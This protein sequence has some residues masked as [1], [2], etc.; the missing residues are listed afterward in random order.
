MVKHS[1]CVSNYYELYHFDAELAFME[2]VLRTPVKI[3]GKVIAANT[4]RNWFE[5]GGL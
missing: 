3:I 1:F 4:K 2:P 5:P